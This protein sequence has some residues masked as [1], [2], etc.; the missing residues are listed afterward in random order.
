MVGI[1]SVTTGRRPVRPHPD[2]KPVVSGLGAGAARADETEGFEFMRRPCNDHNA[3]FGLE[4]DIGGELKASGEGEEAV[5]VAS[6][7]TP[8]QPTLTQLT[9]HRVTHFAYQ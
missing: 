1:G 3:V 7:P 2:H 8:F 5:K 6:L 4:D 9:D